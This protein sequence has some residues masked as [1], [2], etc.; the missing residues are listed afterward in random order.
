MDIVKIIGIAFLAVIIVIILKQYKPEFAMY[1][2]ILAGVAILIICFDKLSGIISLLTSL[3]NK[4]SINGEF[5]GILIKITGIAFLTEF[6]VSVCKDSGETAIANKVD[7]G[8]KIIM[9]SISIPIISTLLET[10]FK[11][12]P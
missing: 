7:I 1:A 6:A 9:I 4:T 8:G 10:I 5:L 12:L 11:V 3:A 2:S